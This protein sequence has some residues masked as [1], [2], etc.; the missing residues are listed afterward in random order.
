MR[1]FLFMICLGGRFNTPCLACIYG[2]GTLSRDSYPYYEQV[3]DH[4]DFRNGGNDDYERV[5]LRGK[6]GNQERREQVHQVADCGRDEGDSQRLGE[7]P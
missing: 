6:V 5:D 1:C 3:E 2:R 4:P 7:Q